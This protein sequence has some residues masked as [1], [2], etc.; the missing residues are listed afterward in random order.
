MTLYSRTTVVDGLVV[1]DSHLSSSRVTMLGQRVLTDMNEDEDEDKASG[2]SVYEFLGDF[3]ER[4]C[5]YVEKSAASGSK[6]DSRLAFSDGARRR[7]QQLSSPNLPGGVDPSKPST[8][9][10]FRPCS[11]TS[12]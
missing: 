9:R 3:T 2:S 4:N 8:I 12:I 1:R 10:C 5:G 11:D 7:E 6:K